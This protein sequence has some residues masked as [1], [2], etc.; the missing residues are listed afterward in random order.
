MDALGTVGI[1]DSVRD[2]TLTAIAQLRAAG[3]KICM[4]SGDSTVSCVSAAYNSGLVLAGTEMVYL[5]DVLN[6]V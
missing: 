6:Q 5:T 1:E 3:I 4:T 2:E